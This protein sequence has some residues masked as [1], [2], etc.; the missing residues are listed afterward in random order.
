MIDLIRRTIS[1]ESI[2]FFDRFSRISEKAQTLR[3]SRRH[4]RDY[5]DGHIV[6]EEFNQI[7]RAVQVDAQR[8]TSSPQWSD[9]SDELAD[10]NEAPQPAP[11]SRP[12]SRV[13]LGQAAWVWG[14]E[15]V[16]GPEVIRYL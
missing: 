3:S 7:Q 5:H 10:R 6:D 8:E 4:H 11:R 2:D 14:P 13:S 12:R 9:G 1:E 15:L 16:V